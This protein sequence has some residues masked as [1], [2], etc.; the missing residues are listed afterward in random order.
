VNASKKSDEGKV[1]KNHAEEVKTEET[2]DKPP[3]DGTATEKPT[4]AVTEILDEG[5]DAKT[6]EPPDNTTENMVQIMQTFW[7]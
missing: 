4:E 2:D 1:N 3:E 5:E 6:V 7:C